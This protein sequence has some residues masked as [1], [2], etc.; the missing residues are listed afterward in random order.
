MGEIKAKLRKVDCFVRN[1][2]PSES[3][4]INEFDFNPKNIVYMDVYFRKPEDC[5]FARGN[6][7]VDV[8]MTDETMV[9]IKLPKEM[10]EKQVLSYVKPLMNG[11]GR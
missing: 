2:I 11:W 7:L 6:W 5:P 10:S 3:D 8:Y 9:C 1:S 4:N